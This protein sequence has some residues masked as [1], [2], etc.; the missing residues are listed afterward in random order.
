MQSIKEIINGPKISNYQGSEKTKNMIAEQ[1]ESRWGK[2]ELKN[3]NPDTSVLPF[4]KWVSL[5]YRPKRGSRSLKSVTFIEQKD[6][7]GNVIR[8]IPRTC[9]LFY[10]RQLEPLSKN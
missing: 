9:H 7:K 4:S 5:G 10:Y 1:I 6:E 3:F 2:A 8:K